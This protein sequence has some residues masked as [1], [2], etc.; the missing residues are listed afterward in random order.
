[1]GSCF[2]VLTFPTI[3]LVNNDNNNKNSLYLIISC[4]VPDT[5]LNYF[6]Y[7]LI[8]SHEVGAVITPISQ[9][10]KLRLREIR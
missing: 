9:L 1:M 10:T 8:E 3:L 4:C 6:A 2:L 7:L 5:V